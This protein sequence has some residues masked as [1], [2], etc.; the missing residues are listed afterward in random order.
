MILDVGCGNTPRGDVNVDRFME[1][2]IHRG[3]AELNVKC[4]PNFVLADSQHLPF[5]GGCFEKV[6]SYHVIEH[7]SE[8]MLMLKEMTRVS[9]H[10]VFVRCP[11]RFSVFNRG[12]GTGSIIPFTFRF[13]LFGNKSH[14]RRGFSVGWFT[15]A[16]EMLHWHVIR[17]KIVYALLG[18]PEEVI[19]KAEKL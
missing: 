13:L 10:Y 7:V 16:F 17:E 9:N 19:V 4:I 1:G 6:V 2:T 11:H 12:N 8:P 14:V 18:T 5:R 3:G 15:Q